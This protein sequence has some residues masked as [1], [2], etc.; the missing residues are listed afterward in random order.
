MRGTLFADAHIH[1]QQMADL[2]H[3]FLDEKS[4]VYFLGDMFDSPEDQK[5]YDGFLDKYDFV[6]VK[7]NHDYWLDLPERVDLGD[8]TLTHGHKI[9]P[10]WSVEK[11]LVKYTPAARRFGIFGPAMS[12]GRFFRGSIFEWAFGNLVIRL[13]DVKKQT[14][15]V[16]V[17]MGHLHHYFVKDNLIILPKFP[18]YAVLRGS[19]L[20]IRNFLDEI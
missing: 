11:Y 8:F 20:E 4:D 15:N 14:G 18:R 12:F 6:W 1:D 5:R 17:I 3:R 9:L 7:G 19:R 2:V 10:T 13:T 16:P